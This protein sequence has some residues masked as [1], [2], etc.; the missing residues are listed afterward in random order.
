[1]TQKFIA[2]YRVSTKS[3]ED[4][5]LGLRAQEKEV[6]DFVRKHLGVVIAEFQEVMSGYS[7][8]RPELDRAIALAKKENATIITAKMDRLSRNLLFATTLMDEGVSFESVDF[9]FAHPL[10]KKLMVMIGEHERDMIAQRVKDALAVLKRDGK[11]LGFAHPEIY[12]HMKSA[13]TKSAESHRANFLRYCEEHRC[14]LDSLLAHDN[15]VVTARKFNEMKIKKY[16]GKAKWLPKEIRNMALKLG[17]KDSV[18]YE[19]AVA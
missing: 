6:Q 11:K 13:T 9:P 5:G 10:V 17:I 12:K 14:L 2:Y 3:Q 16:K 18:K 4:S 1:M 8:K 15:Y 7:K 19:K